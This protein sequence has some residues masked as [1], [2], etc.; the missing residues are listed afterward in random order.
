MWDN[1]E[2]GLLIG[3]AVFCLIV[4]A[5]YF[6]VTYSDSKQ[7]KQLAPVEGKDSYFIQEF[8]TVE[9]TD[10]ASCLTTAEPLDC[11]AMKSIFCKMGCIRV[12]EKGEP[13]VDYALGDEFAKCYDAC[14]A[15]EIAY[16]D[17]IISPDKEVMEDVVDIVDEDTA[18]DKNLDTLFSYNSTKCWRTYVKDTVH[19][20][21]A[22]VGDV[23]EQVSMDDYYAELNADPFKTQ[24]KP[25]KAK[26]L[27]IKDGW[28]RF[29]RIDGDPANKNITT[30]A[31][32]DA[33]C[34]Q[35]SKL[36]K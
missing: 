28:V 14:A 18:K 13:S 1:L 2:K 25:L 23:W 34:V 10:F 22:C 36:E 33:L 31:I 17:Q 7:T 15:D 19:V 3:L 11:L 9:K 8:I 20:C 12:D 35:F 6:S 24:V 29:K 26:I 5:V 4:T 16:R 27:E 32:S 21:M 30:M